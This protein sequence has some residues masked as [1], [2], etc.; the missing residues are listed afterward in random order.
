MEI[1]LNPGFLLWEPCMSRFLTSPTMAKD[2]ILAITQ[3]SRNPRMHTR[4]KWNIGHGTEE[5]YA[6]RNV[7]VNGRKPAPLGL[8]LRLPGLPAVK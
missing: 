2:I 5:H 4:E 1:K 3:Q 6:K 8:M 7:T